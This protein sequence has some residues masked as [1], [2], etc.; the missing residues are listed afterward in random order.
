ML[1]AIG[2]LQPPA[3]APVPET[4]PGGICSSNCQVSERG[5][6]LVRTFE[7][8]MPFPYKDIVGIETVGY[9]YVLRPGDEFEYPMLPPAADELLKKAMGEF[10]PGINRAVA[11]PLSQHQFDALGSWTY[12]LGEGALRSSTMLKRVNAG[13]HDDVPAQMLRWNKARVGGVLQPVRGLTLRRKEE[14]L[15]YSGS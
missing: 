8:Y 10:E 1:V 6:D 9:G 5:Y 2:L 12:N 13:R 11:I 7:G 14:G 3:G 4:Q 15:L